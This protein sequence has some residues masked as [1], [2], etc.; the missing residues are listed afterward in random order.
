MQPV[1]YPLV[2]VYPEPG[3]FGEN[4]DHWAAADSPLGETIDIHT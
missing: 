4:I 2:P 3:Q 1:V